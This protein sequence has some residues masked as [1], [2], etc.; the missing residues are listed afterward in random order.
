[1]AII[2]RI[3]G[4]SGGGIIPDG[5]ELQSTSM[6]YT[7]GGFD[8]K[9]IPLV[10]EKTVSVTVPAGQWTES[11]YVA[12]NSWGGGVTGNNVRVEARSEYY[13]NQ[14]RGR[15]RAYFTGG[16]FESSTQQ[17]WLGTDYEELKRKTSGTIVVWLE[18]K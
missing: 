16:T 9:R 1:M 14:N 17:I 7:F 8:G 2:N 3:G 18:P 5:Y 6:G 15:G 13:N 10:E 4:S 11:S 12:Q